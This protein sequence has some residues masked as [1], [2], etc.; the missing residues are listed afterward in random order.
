MTTS[1]IKSYA[2]SLRVIGQALEVLRIFAFT[3]DKRGEK[4]IV[5]NWEPS[6]LKGVADDVWGKGDFDQ[7]PSSA[8]NS[9]N[10][11]IYTNSDAER[12]ET[13]GRSRRVSSGKPNPYTISSG[14]RLVGD[15]LDKKRAVTFDI[16]WSVESVKVR[17]EA[18]DGG[19]KETSFTMHNLQDLA[20]GMY[21]RRSSR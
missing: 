15:Y 4:Y 17:F 21:L 9:E 18:V 7:M 8:R 3:L 14:L 13:Q 19:P 1:T 16:W 5:R 2:Q 12:L 10:L 20:V 6:F 11:L